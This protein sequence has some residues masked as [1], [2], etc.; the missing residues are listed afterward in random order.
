M[1]ISEEQIVE[2]C[3]EAEW[4]EAFPILY[5]L[6]SDLSEEDLVRRRE[7]FIA[8]GFTLFG[9][10]VAGELMAVAGVDLYPHLSRGID[11]WVHD[12]VT[13][14]SGRSRGLGAKL[15]R[16]IEQWAK[17]QGCSRICVHTRLHRKD[18]QRFYENKLG[19]APSALVY[20]QDVVET[21]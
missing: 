18:A 13:K 10:R 20:Y 11:C 8:N 4:R 21:L 15:M 12:L 14:E 16:H 5:S 1:K 17:S 2:L 9:V 19:Y 7:K 6:R 3:T